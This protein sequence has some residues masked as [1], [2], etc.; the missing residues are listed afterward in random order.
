MLTASNESLSAKPFH[1]VT[2]AYLGREKPPM[3]VIIE[4]ERKREMFCTSQRFIMCYS[5][6]GQGKDGVI[7]LCIIII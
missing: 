3:L 2:S 4:R 7:K 6:R 5:G 1:S